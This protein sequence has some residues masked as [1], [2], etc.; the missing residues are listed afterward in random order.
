MRRVRKADPKPDEKGERDDD[1]EGDGE[2]KV[3]SGGRR[4]E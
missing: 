1:G 4:H 3:E 2:A